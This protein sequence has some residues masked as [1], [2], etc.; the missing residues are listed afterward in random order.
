MKPESFKCFA[1]GSS[2]SRTCQELVRNRRL[3]P[4][5]RWGTA[6]GD[7]GS[8]WIEFAYMVLGESLCPKASRGYSRGRHQQKL[9][10]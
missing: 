1:M 3:N 2:L 5:C 9:L 8:S 6:V 4:K 7:K 10:V